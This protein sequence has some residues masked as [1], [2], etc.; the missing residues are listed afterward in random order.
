[1]FGINQ[2]KYTRLELSCV[3]IYIIGFVGHRTLQ[4]T[5]STTIFLYFACILPSIALGVLNDN[6]THGKIGNFLAWQYCVK[7]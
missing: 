6:N 5:A 3:S 2:D 1:M 7:R 4:K